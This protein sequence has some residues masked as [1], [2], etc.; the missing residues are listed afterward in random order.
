MWHT[1]RHHTGML[2]TAAPERIPAL[3]SDLAF[4]HGR[5]VL[6]AVSIRSAVRVGGACLGVG[7]AEALDAVGLGQG[8]GRVVQTATYPGEVSAQ[9][10]QCCSAVGRCFPVVL[11]CF[12]TII[13]VDAG[14]SANSAGAHEKLVARTAI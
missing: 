12:C 8:L 10:R 13:L 7:T 5:C 14:G 6:G 1:H 4:R 3:V 9:H 2:R 11:G